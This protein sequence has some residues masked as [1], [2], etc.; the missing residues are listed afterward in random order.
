MGMRIVG[1][2][3]TQVSIRQTGER[4]KSHVLRQMRKEAQEIKKISQEQAPRDEGNLEEA[5]HVT[6]VKKGRERTV[7]EIEVGGVVNGVNVDQ[8]ALEMHES[9]YNLGPES[10][11]KQAG[12]QRIVGRKYLERAVEERDREMQRRLQ[13]AAEEA[14]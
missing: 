4:A 2:R 3:E 14:L 7:I 13:E 11:K 5:H 9:V 6:E 10:L 1:L 8:Y 12:Q